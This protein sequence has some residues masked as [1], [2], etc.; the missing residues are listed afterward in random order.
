MVIYSDQ[1]FVK[2]KLLRAEESGARVVAVEV[3]SLEAAVEEFF[4]EAEVGRRVREVAVALDSRADEVGA[5]LDEAEAPVGGDVRAA[6]V[7]SSCL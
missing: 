1:S 2:V 5:E 6:P 7:A 4:L 3:F